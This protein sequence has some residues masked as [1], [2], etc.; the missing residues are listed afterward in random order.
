MQRPQEDFSDDRSRG[1]WITDPFG[2]ATQTSPRRCRIEVVSG[3]DAGLVAEFVS[4]TLQVGARPTCDLALSDPCVSGLHLEIRL[5]EQGYLLRDLGSTNG[6]Y[7]GSCR[8][9]EVYL[10]EDA[11]LELGRTRLRFTA[12]RED[13]EAP[14]IREERYGDLV[15]RSPVMREL[16]ERIEQ[17]AASDCTVLVLGETGTGK[18]LV[19]ETIHRRSFR[20]HRKFVV[21]DCGAIP[22]TLVDSELFGHERGSFTGAVGTYVGAFERA[23]GGTLFLDEIGEFS[24]DLQPKLLRTLARKVLRRVGGSQDIAV[25]VRLVAATNRDLAEEVRRGRFRE[26]LYHRLNVVPI[27][28]PPL[29]ERKEDIPLLV[30]HFLS[31]TPGGRTLRLDERAMESLLRYDWPGNV[32]ELKNAVERDVLLRSGRGEAAQ[33]HRTVRVDKDQPP[34][35]GL[36]LMQFLVDTD[37]PFKD[38]KQEMLD[39]FERRFLE[40]LLVWCGGNVSRAARTAGVDRMSIYNM[41]DRLGIR[42]PGRRNA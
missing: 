35:H 15:G 22:S 16:Y 14:V 39:E 13:D 27:R 28:V 12:L 2:N 17:V 26:D 7:I 34:R 4:P 40:S 5:D 37:I 8:V 10:P 23:H 31:K 9:T 38:A 29:R 25:D 24:L 33:R 1:T 3:P 18:E 11:L 19:A 20:S 21:L 32:R 36:S 6:T 41:M 30:E 42:R